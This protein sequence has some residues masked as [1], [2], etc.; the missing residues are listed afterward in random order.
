MGKK[1]KPW[2][3][4]SVFLILLLLMSVAAYAGSVVSVPAKPVERPPLQ[5]ISEEAPAKNFVTESVDEKNNY[6]TAHYKENGVIC[7]PSGQKLGY[8]DEPS[9]NVIMPPSCVI[10]SDL[11]NLQYLETYNLTKMLNSLRNQQET[12]TSILAMY[13]G[14]GGRCAAIFTKYESEGSADLALGGMASEDAVLKRVGDYYAYVNDTFHYAVWRK[15]LYVVTTSSYYDYTSGKSDEENCAAL[16]EP[17]LNK[18]GSDLTPAE[19]TPASYKGE[20]STAELIIEKVREEEGS[21]TGGAPDED[22]LVMQCEDSRDKNG[23]I[24]CKKVKASEMIFSEEVVEEEIP[25]AT[26]DYLADSSGEG[27]KKI[28]R[29][30]ETSNIY[31][32]QSDDGLKSKLDEYYNSRA[33][34]YFEKYGNRELTDD[35]AAKEL[36]MFSQ[37]M[38]PEKQPK[39]AGSASF[40]GKIVSFVKNIFS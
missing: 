11:G 30:A 2:L 31:L 5:S 32:P 24:V 10:A 15:G 40:F 28:R 12:I 14:S 23:T 6:A 39:K 29:L 3:C 37:E 35:E 20:N 33:G 9:V 18:I 8:E 17:Y 16:I 26:A 22:G 36:K 19:A 13:K 27:I 1:T 7:I 38:Y 34:E 25:A 4:V 21:G